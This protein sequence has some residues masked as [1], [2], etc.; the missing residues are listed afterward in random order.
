MEK[1]AFY[2]L[3]NKLEDEKSAKAKVTGLA[4]IQVKYGSV[5]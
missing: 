3:E 4:D 2:R 1:D 5:L